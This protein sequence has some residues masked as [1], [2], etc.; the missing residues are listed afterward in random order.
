MYWFELGTKG[1]KVTTLINQFNFVSLIF[2]K[3]K[4]VSYFFL[5]FTISFFLSCFWKATDCLLFEALFRLER[6]K[7]NTSPAEWNL[8]LFCSILHYFLHIITHIFLRASSRLTVVL[9]SS[10]SWKGIVLSANNLTLCVFRIIAESACRT[11]LRQFD[12]NLAPSSG[13]IIHLMGKAALLYHLVS[14]IIY[15]KF[16]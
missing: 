9:Q 5:E 8:L 12:P 7:Q 13:I 15:N 16:R 2:R 10:I 6:L 14:R 4:R 3:L 1:W 11:F